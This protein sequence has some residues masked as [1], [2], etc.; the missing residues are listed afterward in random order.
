MDRISLLADDELVRVLSHLEIAA[1]GVVAQ[2]STHFKEIAVSDVMWDAHA[3]SLCNRCKLDRRDFEGNFLYGLTEDARNLPEYDGPPLRMPYLTPDN[4]G[5]KIADEGLQYRCY[6]TA[7]KG[8][9]TPSDATW[10]TCTYPVKCCG[11]LH[12]NR[13]DFE[14]HCKDMRHYE[15][16]QDINGRG[17]LPDSWIDPRVL[18]TQRE[19][20]ALP[21]REQYLRVRTYIDAILPQIERACEPSNWDAADMANLNLLSANGKSFMQEIIADNDSED[22][23]FAD[24]CATCEFDLEPHSIGEHICECVLRGF[25]EGSGV[26]SEAPDVPYFSV[27]DLL[28]GGLAS[29]DPDGGSSS[30]ATWWSGL[31]EL[32]EYHYEGPY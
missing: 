5:I 28:V 26:Y 8:K 6:P 18:V 4:Y 16:M 31:S 13:A 21:K 19:F 9:R 11:V 12:A 2:V 32:F 27:R 10:V 17:R 30:G 23:Y 25:E 15:R 14:A 1:L 20:E 3:S 7:L 22:E 29:C 24:I